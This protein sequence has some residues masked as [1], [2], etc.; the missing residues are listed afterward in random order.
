MD[1]KHLSHS[2]CTEGP[3]LTADGVL[4]FLGL[5]EVGARKR[6]ASCFDFF[7]ASHAWAP[8]SKLTLNP[9][10]SEA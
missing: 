10:E 3:L 6:G 1:F 7:P 5:V 8:N 2:T 9:K 4:L